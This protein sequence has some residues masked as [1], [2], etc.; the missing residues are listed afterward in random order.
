MPL[1][2]GSRGDSTACSKR[3]FVKTQAFLAN[4]GVFVEDLFH[5][6][7]DLQAMAQRKNMKFAV[8]LNGTTDIKWEDLDLMQNMPEV[9]FYDYTKW[10]SAKRATCR[11]TTT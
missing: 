1:L 4:P 11:R 10:P 8:R 5:D 3:A 9:Q 2:R 6:I 7:C